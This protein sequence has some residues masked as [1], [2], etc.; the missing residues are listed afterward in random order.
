MTVTLQHDPRLE[1]ITSAILFPL[2]TLWI[3][4]IALWLRNEESS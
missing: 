4:V 2:F 1:T 3:V